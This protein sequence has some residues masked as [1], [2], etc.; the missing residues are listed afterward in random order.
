VAEH[1]SEY[2]IKFTGIPVGEHE[3]SFHI[4]DSFF[5][6]HPATIIRSADVDVK[7][8]LRKGS[9]AMELDLYLSGEVKVECGRCLEEFSMPI[10]VEKHLLVRMVESPKREDDDDDAIHIAL[11]AHEIDLNDHLYDFLALEVPYIPV[12]PDD[13]NGV[14]ECNPEVLKLIISE[15]AK[16]EAPEK[17]TPENDRWEA[18]R[19]LKMN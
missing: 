17:G 4:G 10:D 13:E 3:F 15:K 6:H 2:V 9:G 8:I 12:H 5:E 14:P 7:A 11:S 19:K 16:T 18:L 1:H